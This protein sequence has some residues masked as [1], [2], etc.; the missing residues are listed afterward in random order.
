MDLGEKRVKN[1]VGRKESKGSKWASEWGGFNVPLT[2]RAWGLWRE[3]KGK[4][5][6]KILATVLIATDD[7]I[8]SVRCEKW[9]SC[10]IAVTRGF[11]S[12]DISRP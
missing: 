1:K 8:Y 4:P 3:G 6:A 9:Y 7:R 10:Y 11:R 2:E 12:A 5:L